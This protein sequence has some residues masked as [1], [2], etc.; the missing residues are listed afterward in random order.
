[1]PAGRR[2]P[3]QSDRHRGE[4]GG[5]WAGLVHANQD[6]CGDEAGV[7]GQGQDHEW[8]EPRSMPLN[9]GQGPGYRVHLPFL[10]PRDHADLFN[11]N[12][13][14]NRHHTDDFPV[15]NR[16]IHLEVHRS[17]LTSEEGADAIRQ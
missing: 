10:G 15:G 9:L 3:N 1:M 5:P 7:E 4:V 2:F 13:M 14:Q 17:S 11:P 16:L 6:H 8:Q 12:R